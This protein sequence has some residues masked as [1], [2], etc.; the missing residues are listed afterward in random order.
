MMNASKDAQGNKPSAPR[1]PAPITSNA[2]AF[3]SGNRPPP[4]GAT[5]PSRSTVQQPTP[6]VI[7]QRG[8]SSILYSLRQKGNPVLEGIKQH[9]KEI[10]DIPAD[11]VLGATTCALFLS[12]KYHRL[13]PEYIYNRIREL[14]G[15]Y[16]LRILLILV[17]I[18]NHEAS[19]KELSKT[20]LINNVTIILCWS[21]AEAGRYLDLYKT[22]EHSAPTMI[23]APQSTSHS[24]KLIEFITVPR[25][26]NKTDAL[27]LVS[28]FGSVRTAVNAR[29]EEILM[30]QGWG[31]TKVKHWH[32]AVSEPLRTRK[33]AK[34]GLGREDTNTTQAT[35]S[36]EPSRPEAE[37][38]ALVYEAALATDE[39]RRSMSASNSTMPDADRRPAKRAAEDEFMNDPDA[40]EE[41]AMRELLN[42]PPTISV[43]AAKSITAT[44]S[45]TRNKPSEPEVSDGVMAALAKLREQG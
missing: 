8:S 12:L 10:A 13:H 2:R 39:M 35:L 38:A 15:R 42:G 37:P 24:D 16:N 26:V 9:P 28:N 44:A 7:H 14:H 21:A 22:Y 30:L 45:A 20:S 19:L 36:R 17:D 23:K 34:R 31:Q 18:S 29:P 1:T 33:A 5:G 27:C 43:A 32:Q 4:A 3:Q 11:Y 6:E 41:E 25:S 40:D